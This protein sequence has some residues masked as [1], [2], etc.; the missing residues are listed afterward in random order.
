M[1]IV[2]G[3]GKVI[4]YI[5]DM[6]TPAAHFIGEYD[7]NIFYDYGA[8][9]MRHGDAWIFDGKDWHEL[10]IANELVSSYEATATIEYKT[11]C[12]NCGAH[13]IN[14]KCKY[15]GTEDYGRR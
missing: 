7:S 6:T 2:Y 3:D 5:E 4:G 8:I 1:T 15:C 12:P 10:G 13:M 9:T 14:H 11:N